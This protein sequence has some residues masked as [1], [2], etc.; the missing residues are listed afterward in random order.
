MGAG[1]NHE[2][3]ARNRICAK[4]RDAPLDDCLVL[5]RRTRIAV[6]GCE[7]RKVAARQEINK[8]TIAR[9]NN[10]PLWVV[11][12]C[13]NL[14]AVGAYCVT[15]NQHPGS[16]DVLGGLRH[17]NAGRGKSQAQHCYSAQSRCGTT[18]H[19]VLLRLSAQQVSPR[20]LRTAISEPD[21]DASG[22][23]WASATAVQGCMSTHS[24]RSLANFR[25]KHEY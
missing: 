22:S 24:Q 13:R 9:E 7:F 23:C 17:S 19:R 3:S 4:R 14:D 12:K 25:S 2:V 6:V 10:D 18:L 16:D 1:I 15:R 8:T 5:L 21:T 11:T 20:E